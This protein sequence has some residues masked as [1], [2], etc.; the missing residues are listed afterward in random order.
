MTQVGSYRVLRR[1]GAG[2]MGVVYLARRLGA[3]GFERE[4]ALKVI[5]AERPSQRDVKLLLREGRAL[6]TLNHRGIV[7]VFDLF[8]EG[9]ALCL[10]M[11]YLPGSN[12]RHLLQRAGPLPWPAA[13]F[14]GAEAARALEAAHGAR[15]PEAPQG[16]VHRDVSPTNIMV[17]ADGAVKLLDFGLARPVGGEVSVSGIEGKLRYLPPEAAA[18]TGV[19]PGADVYALGVV[20]YEMV[21]GR[22]PFAGDNELA[23]LSAIMHQTVEP[24]ARL[25]PE[26]PAALDRLIL[27]ALSRDQGPRPTAG[28]LAAGLEELAA[29]R[30]GA[31]DLAGLV[32]AAMKGELQ[33]GRG[34]AAHAERQLPAPASAVRRVPRRTAWMVAA[35]LGLLGGAAAIFWLSGGWRGPTTSSLQAGSAGASPAA[36]ARADSSPRGASRPALAASRPAPA[37]SQPAPASQAAVE[38]RPGDQASP[39]AK[40]RRTRGGRPHKRT[41]RRRTEPD[42]E[43]INPFQ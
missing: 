30:F 20:L 10:V 4:V 39:E 29:G 16:L 33:F 2:G 15:S 6:S 26:L 13:C 34:D 36:A 12:L 25:V 42:D 1:L 18:G 27:R 37:A 19:G 7:Q 5:R 23:L 8:A 31:S 43:P 41:P 40:V 35:A 32:R 3:R 24:P 38:Q 21:A 22:A 11:E 14:I 28:E 9:D 17:C